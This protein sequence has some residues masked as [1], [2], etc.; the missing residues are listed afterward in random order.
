MVAAACRETLLARG[1]GE[2]GSELMSGAM[3]TSCESQYRRVAKMR[4]LQEVRI[5]EKDEG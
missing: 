2:G 5:G 3:M 4:I 1:E